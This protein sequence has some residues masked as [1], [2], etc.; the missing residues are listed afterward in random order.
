M[1]WAWSTTR[2]I[3]PFQAASMTAEEFADAIE[4]LITAARDEGL[5]D[6]VII[7]G[8][9]KPPTHCVRDFPDHCCP[10]GWCWSELLPSVPMMMRH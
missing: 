7:A 9:R 2:W 5:S 3:G 1:F 8:S 10:L 4:K 6:G